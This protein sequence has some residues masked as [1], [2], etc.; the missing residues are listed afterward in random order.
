MRALKKLL[1]VLIVLLMLVSPVATIGTSMVAKA[2]YAS[3]P[4]ISRVWQY[5]IDIDKGLVNQINKLDLSNVNDYNK[6]VTVMNLVNNSKKESTDLLNLAGCYDFSVDNTYVAHSLRMGMEN[7]FVFQST[8]GLAGLVFNGNAVKYLTLQNVDKDRY[9]KSL[10][11]FMK[12]S[13]ADLELLNTTKE[14]VSILKNLAKVVD[15][16]TARSA[17]HSIMLSVYA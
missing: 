1:A 10:K 3:D 17:I 8:L 9:K 15:N 12:A 16:E 6:Y 2:S 5:C 14:V 11:S 4:L 7:D 13:S